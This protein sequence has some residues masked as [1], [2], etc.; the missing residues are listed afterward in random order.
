LKRASASCIAAQPSG[1]F[2]GRAIVYQDDFPIRNNFHQ[3]FKQPRLKQRQCF[4]PVKA[5][6]DDAQGDLAGR[7]FLELVTWRLRSRAVGGESDTIGRG[8]GRGRVEKQKGA[9]L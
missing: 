2:I 7:T 4:G 6:N 8:R 5:R 1:L 3:G 9:S